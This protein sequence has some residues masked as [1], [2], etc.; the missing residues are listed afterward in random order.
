MAKEQL[1]DD[2]YSANVIE[3]VTVARAYCDFLE[4]PETH[5]RHDFVEKIRKLLP[6]IYLKS[7]LLPD[8]EPPNAAVIDRWA[9]EVE[10]NIIQERIRAVLGGRDDYLEV[11]D[12][13]MQY[14]EEPITAS[15]SENLSDIWQDLKDFLMNYRS[16]SPDIMLAALGL[17]KSNFETFWGQRLVN[18]LR[19]VH[20]LAFNTLNEFHTEEGDY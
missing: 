17:C 8:T 6:L 4:T 12:A 15:I 16:D 9:T 3:F 11:F 5:S 7:S 1:T 13:G 14:C 18:C 20:N 19:A 10:Y 2:I